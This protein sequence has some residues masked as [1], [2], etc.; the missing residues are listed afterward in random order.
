MAKRAIDEQLLFD[1]ALE[2][3][4]RHSFEEASIN[5]IIADARIT[6]G[7]FYYRFSTKYDLYI[8]LLKES[9]RRKWQFIDE[10]VK[11]DQKPGAGKDIFDFFRIQAESGARFAE[12]YPKYH[13]LSKMFSREKS[14]PLYKKAMKD[15]ETVDES[16]LSQLIKVSYESGNF[17]KEYSPE[18]IDKLIKG[19][20]FAFDDILFKNEDFE[21]DK[22][23][24]YLRQFTDFMK[25]GLKA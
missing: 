6:K 9:A 25:F 13:Q 16:G 22:C 12:A 2:E 14:S 19:L 23:M 24:E 3:F 20:F 5:K 21:L 18:F 17:K 1:A 15:L 8:Y 11:P 7:S 10:N 4:S